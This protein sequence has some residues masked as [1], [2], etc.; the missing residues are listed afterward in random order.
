MKKNILT[1]RLEKMWK[2]NISNM[3]K[4][5]KKVKKVEHVESTGNYLLYFS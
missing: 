5:V 3:L 2:K 4:Y 1:M